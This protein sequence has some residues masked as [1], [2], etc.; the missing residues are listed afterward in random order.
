M[1]SMA[2]SLCISISASLENMS[3]LL[4]EMLPPIRNHENMSLLL[5][6]MISPHLKPCKCDTFCNILLVTNAS[7]DVHGI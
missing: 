2:V 7:N 4:I 3:I 5:I 6:E 1:N